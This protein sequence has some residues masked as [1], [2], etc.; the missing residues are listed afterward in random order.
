M[1]KIGLLIIAIL[2]I[3]FAFAQGAKVTAKNVPMTLNAI[4]KVSASSQ[5]TNSSFSEAT[6]GRL[7]STNDSVTILGV[8][9]AMPTST[10]TTGAVIL[11]V[12]N[13]GTQLF[14]VNN[15]GAIYTGTTAATSGTFA[16]AGTVTI[17]VVNGLITNIQ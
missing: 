16:T 11:G 2:S 6:R 9:K 8:V 17:T 7:Q 13:T 3:N 12:N 10:L 4:P 5:I 1:K 14:R 15:S